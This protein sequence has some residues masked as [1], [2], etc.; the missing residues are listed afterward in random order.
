MPYIL[1]ESNGLK[2]LNEVIWK[3]IFNEKLIFS[4]SGSIIL[5]RVT[6]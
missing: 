6:S 5:E 2:L 3:E 4:A 1:F